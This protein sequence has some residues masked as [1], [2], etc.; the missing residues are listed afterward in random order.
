MENKK[1]ESTVNWDR[2]SKMCK[3]YLKKDKNGDPFFMG[4]LTHTL[5]ILIQK[6]TGQW[7]KEGEYVAYVVPIEFKKIEEAQKESFEEESSPF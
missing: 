4:D 5:K 7:A 3:L 1:F 6:Q 2:K